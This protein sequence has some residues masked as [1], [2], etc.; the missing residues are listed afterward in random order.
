[1]V[2]DST[3][4]CH[5]M[6]SLLLHLT[7]RRLSLHVVSSTAC[8]NT[9]IEA[10]SIEA[11]SIEAVS[12]EAVST[13]AVSTEAV[14]LSECRAALQRDMAQEGQI[15]GHTG[16]GNTPVH[17]EILQPGESLQ[18]HDLQQPGQRTAHCP[19]LP[20]DRSRPVWIDSSMKVL[21]QK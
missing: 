19:L 12:T 7:T 8:H 14:D 13:E 6:H 15:E 17:F 18:S 1:M 20:L 5:S 4:A 2:T 11:V 21:R 3:S 9:S 16:H 10:V